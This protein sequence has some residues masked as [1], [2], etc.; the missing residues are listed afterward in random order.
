MLPY[1]W[2]GLNSISSSSGRHPTTSC[3]LAA[4]DHRQIL[5]RRVPVHDSDVSDARDRYPTVGG[6]L[7]DVA[8][9]GELGRRAPAAGDV[10]CQCVVEDGDGVP[11]GLNLHGE[12]PSETNAGGEGIVED[13]VDGG[14][15]RAGT[16]DVYGDPVIVEA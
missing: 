5:P 2:L 14:I 3:I 9:E 11:S 8:Q 1:S 16:T 4:T 13:I 15:F 6:F 7:V 10:G 12:V